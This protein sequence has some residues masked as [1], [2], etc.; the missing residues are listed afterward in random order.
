MKTAMDKNLSNRGEEKER[1]ELRAERMQS[2]A[3]GASVDLETDDSVVSLQ[4]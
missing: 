2:S 1:R 3:S 4:A